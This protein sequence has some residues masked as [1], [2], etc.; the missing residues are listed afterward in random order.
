M[1]NIWFLGSF[2][3]RTSA[4]DDTGAQSN[5]QFRGTKFRKTRTLKELVLQPL[6][7]RSSTFYL[8]RTLTVVV[9]W[10]RKAVTKFQI[11]NARPKS[12]RRL[13]RNKRKTTRRWVEISKL[14]SCVRCITS[15]FV[16]VVHEQSGMLKRVTLPTYRTFLDGVNVI[17]AV[18]GQL[19]TAG[20]MYFEE[21]MFL[22][23]GHYL[24]GHD[25]NIHEVDCSRTFC[26][27]KGYNMA[28]NSKKIEIFGHI[29]C[30][31]SCPVA[32]LWLLCLQLMS[33]L[34]ASPVVHFCITWPPIAKIQ[35]WNI[36][37]N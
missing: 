13:R 27:G 28:S 36:L 10:F 29:N 16:D 31:W 17:H 24:Y 34:G 20:S 37:A 18:Y 15:V 12:C 25:M 1:N 32:Y 8:G 22:H 19:C 21:N 26:S 6:L 30:Q 5:I 11:V 2:C 35:T 3:H 23:F 7:I 9:A 14:H 4:V 33:L